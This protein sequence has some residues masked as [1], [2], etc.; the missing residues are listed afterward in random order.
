MDLFDN[1]NDDSCIFPLTDNLGTSYVDT[2]KLICGDDDAS[3]QYP[4]GMGNFKSRKNHQTAV[5]LSSGSRHFD[6]SYKHLAIASACPN[7]ARYRWNMAF[8]RVKS[9]C[10]PWNEFNLDECPTET[11]VR[12]R[13]N[14]VKKEWT[15]D[16]CTVKIEAKKFEQGAMRACF[17]L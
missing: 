9:I 4:I 1:D 16:E 6:S 2:S 11:A 10:D 5:A 3:N 14:A 12:H 17:R 13:Y 15:Q 7:R 8:K